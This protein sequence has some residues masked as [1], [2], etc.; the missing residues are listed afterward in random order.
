MLKK[1][2]RSRLAFSSS[3]LEHA[4]LRSSQSSSSEDSQA[5]DSPN[6]IDGCHKAEIEACQDQS[7]TNV[8][9]LAIAKGGRRT[10]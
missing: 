1:N 2:L 3:Q 9:R 4:G 8:P 5:R 10:F 6:V 7:F